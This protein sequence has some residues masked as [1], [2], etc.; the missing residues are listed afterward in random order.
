MNNNLKIQYL[1][2]GSVFRFML[3]IMQRLR[4]AASLHLSH[5]YTLLFIHSYRASGLS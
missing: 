1:V 5:C 2:F 3:E 4:S